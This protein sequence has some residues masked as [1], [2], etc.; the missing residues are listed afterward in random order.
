M[1]IAIDKNVYSNLSVTEKNIID[2]IF[3]N[4]KNP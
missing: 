4:Q 3:K 2:F 1:S